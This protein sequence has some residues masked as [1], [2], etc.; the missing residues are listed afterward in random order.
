MFGVVVTVESDAVVGARDTVNDTGLKCNIDG[1]VHARTPSTIHSP[2]LLPSPPPRG[3]P[4]FEAASAM[5]AAVQR[6]WERFGPLMREAVRAASASQPSK[7]PSVASSTTS[8]SS[9][10]S[11]PSTLSTSSIPSTASATTPSSTQSISSP[12]RD[13]RLGDLLWAHAMVAS[14]AVGLPTG[15][16]GAEELALVPGLD[17]ANHRTQS[18]FR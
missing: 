9:T 11:I 12:P 7:S 5:R 3:T 4:L 16:H 14:R 13:P 17:F 15:P 6:Q 18:P 10:S 8:T 2:C 1:T